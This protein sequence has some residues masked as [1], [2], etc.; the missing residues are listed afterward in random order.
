[1]IKLMS[2]K[3]RTILINLFL[4]I[5][6]LPTFAWTLNYAFSKAVRQSFD[7]RLVALM[8]VIVADLEVM[9]DGSLS[10]INTL[11]EKRF[12][13]VYSG[14]YWQLATADTQLNA[15][16]SLWDFRLT[17][18]QD[19]QVGNLIVRDG[20]GPQA[21][22][23]RIAERD[24]TL[25][26]YN[27]VIHVMVGGN[28][29][30]IRREVIAFQSIL[31]PGTVII[32]LLLGIFLWLQLRWS[33]A[34]LAIMQTQLAGLK[35][36][37]RQRLDGTFPVELQDLA[38]ALNDVLE[39]DEKLMQRGRETAANLAHSLKTPL[40]VIKTHIDELP[41]AQAKPLNLEL[42]RM[43]QVIHYQLARA[44]THTPH[45]LSQKI[46]VDVAIQ[47]VLNMFKRLSEQNGKEFNVFSAAVW[48][49]VPAE[50]IQEII[51]NLLENALKY[52][53]SRLAIRFD[54][55]TKAVTIE[56]DGP[57]LTQEQRLSALTR[58][59]RLDEQSPGNGIGLAVVA[60]L[61]AAYDGELSFTDSPLGGLAVTV[62]FK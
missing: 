47:P 23:L 4:I 42:Q 5:I 49:S 24:V 15:S 21:Q 51:G 58:G 32:G 57:G 50:D 60:E 1:M 12:E 3:R 17:P 36:G 6:V 61:V 29:A 56:D 43:Q 10:T 40:A 59:V 18:S 14:W 9:P 52:S 53:T 28:A 41:Q 33:L 54:A 30:E 37:Q 20:I 26:G 22:A 34:P 2:I 16:R 45:A 48:W 35:S 7:A 25:P 8:N 38:G 55:S 44:N 39:R 31:G 46:A 62:G 27:K 11:G 19:G 13:Q